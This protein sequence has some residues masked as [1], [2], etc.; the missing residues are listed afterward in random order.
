MILLALV[1]VGL[2]A[3][4]WFLVMAPKRAEVTELDDKI[5]TAQA[6]AEEQEQLAAFAETAKDGYDNDYQKLVVLGKAVPSDSDQASL[7]EQINAKSVKAGIDF[8]SVILASEGE[9]AEAPAPPVTDDGGAPAPAAPAEG[10]AAPVA[11]TPAPATE[12]AA[13]TLPIGATVGPAGLPVMPYDLSFTGGF[14]DIADFMEGLDGMVKTKAKGE[15]IGVAGR[16]L[17]VDGFSLAPNESAGFPVLD[18]NLH[19]TTF[20]TPADQGITGGATPGA[21]AP[22][23]SITTT[24]APAPPVAATTAP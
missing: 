14:F 13:A 18:A 16:L 3:A 12:A 11:A 22:S 19:V 7:V 5:A 2:V 1:G 21:P 9:A 20:V 17:T 15:S 8:K 23:T 4:F 6:A 24:P 10:E